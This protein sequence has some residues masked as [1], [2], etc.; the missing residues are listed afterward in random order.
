MGNESFNNSDNPAAVTSPPD[1]KM[2]GRGKARGAPW[3]FITALL[4][5]LLLGIWG[6]IWLA[7]HPES[8][9]YR[10]FLEASALTLKPE[11][12]ETDEYLVFMSEDTADNRRRLLA[13]SPH[14][15]YLGDSLF[16]SVIVVRVSD[17]LNGT[18]TT[19]R[20][21]EYVNMVFKYDPIFGCH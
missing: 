16:P 18:L 14:V 9:A 6:L 19:L 2:S 4:A 5:A 11:R 1:L 21:E 8:T 7:G 20:N 13:T 17:D 12:V 15:S 3:I 10:L